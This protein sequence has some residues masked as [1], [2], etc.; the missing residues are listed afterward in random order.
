MTEQDEDGG[1]GA[2]V[3]TAPTTAT[4]AKASTPVKSAVKGAAAKSSAKTTGTAP[5][6][7]TTKAAT[8]KAAGTPV[9]KSAADLKGDAKLVRLL[10]NAVEAAADDDGWASVS[11]V[12]NRISN[13]SSFDSRNL[14]YGSLTKLL[15]AIELFDFRDEGTSNLAV[16][17]RRRAK[18]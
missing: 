14:G 4:E 6:K 2:A 8:K 12:G 16:R 7:A 11:T 13:Q 3:E 17:D 9:R 1:N 18:G 15:K 5:A 10:R